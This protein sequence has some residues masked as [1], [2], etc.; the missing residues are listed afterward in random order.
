MNSQNAKTLINL[1]SLSQVSS[2]P[3]TKYRRSVLSEKNQVTINGVFVFPRH[4]YT[5][6]WTPNND[7]L[8]TKKNFAKK[9]KKNMP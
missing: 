4:Y 7:S 6:Y 9:A 3:I 1:G 8:Q 2:V 5:D